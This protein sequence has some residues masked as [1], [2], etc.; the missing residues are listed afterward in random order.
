M[1]EATLKQPYKTDLLIEFGM[2]AHFSQ[3]KTVG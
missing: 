1:S 2:P 3:I